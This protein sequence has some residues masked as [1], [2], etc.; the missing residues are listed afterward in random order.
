MDYQT[1]EV[2]ASYYAPDVLSDVFGQGSVCP[3]GQ[4]LDHDG[5]LDC[6]GHG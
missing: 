4:P 2:I 6:P 3:G 5:M 1:P